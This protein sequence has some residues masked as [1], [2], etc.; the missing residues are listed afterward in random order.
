MS[1][2]QQDE[3]ALA[4]EWVARVGRFLTLE[5]AAAQLDISIADLAQKATDNLALALHTGDDTILFPE[6]QFAGAS[7][8]QLQKVLSVMDPLGVDPWGCA[9][10]LTAARS[11]LDGLT[12]WQALANNRAD[13]VF[14]LTKEIGN[15]YQ[16]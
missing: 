5:T 11:D 8:Q 14:S 9:L 2:A 13:E 10:W 1:S 7:P 15:A 6:F 16:A 12:P 4:N 3:A